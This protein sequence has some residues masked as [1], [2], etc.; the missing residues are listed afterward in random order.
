MY[1]IQACKWNSHFF[2][3]AFYSQLWGCVLHI[4]ACFTWDLI[5]LHLKTGSRCRL[6]GDFYYD[7]CNSVNS[8]VTQDVEGKIQR[9]R[10]VLSE[11]FN[12]MWQFSINPR[13]SHYMW[14]AAKQPYCKW[15]LN[16]LH[17]QVKDHKNLCNEMSLHW[18][19]GVQ[20]SHSLKK[21]KCKK[22]RCTSG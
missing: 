21:F 2:P 22:D 5:V 6:R 11:K 13:L 14:C 15:F 20:L 19:I 12:L 9:W 8:V 3:P 1:M 4:G 7:R 10:E 17:S 16:I 18:Q